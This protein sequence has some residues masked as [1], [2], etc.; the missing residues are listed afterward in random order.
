MSGTKVSYIGHE[1]EPK[2]V[3]LVIDNC[4]SQKKLDFGIHPGMVSINA[5]PFIDRVD[6]ATIDILLISQKDKG[7]R[8][9]LIEAKMPDVLIIE[10]TYGVNCTSRARNGRSGSR[11]R[12]GALWCG[13]AG[14]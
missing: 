8:A 12:S 13:P 2:L 14:A 6:I 10:S 4:L 7:L 5:L 9:H 1:V 11:T 3:T